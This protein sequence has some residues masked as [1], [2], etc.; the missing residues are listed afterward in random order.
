MVKEA[1]AELNRQYLNEISSVNAISIHVRRGDY[2]TDGITNAVHGV[3]G[4][5]Y[6]REAI[7]YMAAKI[8]DPRFYIF[9]DDMEWT[10]AHLS[11]DPYPAIFIDHN[12]NVGQEDMRLMYSCKHH[13]IANSSFSWWG[14]W[15]NN[16]PGKTVIAPAQWSNI[17]GSESILPDSWI[18][19]N[20]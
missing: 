13:I 5:D 16:Y 11:T 7:S 17:P 8:N 1:P 9:S 20:R 4:I 12:N 6:Y 10:K 15:L 18:K 2:V 3:C 14:A 19:Y